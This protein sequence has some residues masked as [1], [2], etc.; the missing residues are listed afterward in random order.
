[1]SFDIPVHHE[2][3]VFGE[4]DESTN[5]KNFWSECRKNP[6]HPK[7]MSVLDFREHYLPKVQTDKQRKRLNAMIDLTA[8]VRVTWTSPCRP[9]KYPFDEHRGTDKRRVGTGLVDR[10][11]VG[12]TRNQ[13]CPCHG[14]GGKIVR[15]FWTFKVRTARHVIFDTEE[16]NHAEIE[17][18]YDDETCASDGRIKTMS[19][20]KVIGSDLVRDKC[21]FMCVSHDETLYERIS[22]AR[23]SW[24][25]LSCKLT[26]ED[27][28]DMGLLPS[29]SGECAPALII[30]HPHGQPKKITVGYVRDKEHPDVKYDTDT[31]PGSSGATVFWFHPDLKG[32]RVHSWENPVHS[33]ADLKHNLNIGYRS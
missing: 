5:S 14:C 24:A 28:H 22:S 25:D 13:P 12:V 8:K 18:F 31:C 6:G 27:V 11:N 26:H 1:M 33:G 10:V 2:C 21:T 20:L 17:L 30:S 15:D 7:F 3:Q 23:K 16:A 32:H 19:G 4:G 29:C 9:D